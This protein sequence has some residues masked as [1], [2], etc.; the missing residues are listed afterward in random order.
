M[1]YVKIVIRPMRI[2]RIECSEVFIYNCHQDEFAFKLHRK[3]KM[4][5]SEKIQ[6]L[7]TC[8]RTKTVKINEGSCYDNG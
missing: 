4:K 7:R 2:R 1:P 8:Q 3:G 6:I 5:G